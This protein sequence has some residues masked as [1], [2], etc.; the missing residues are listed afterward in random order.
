MYHTAIKRMR[1][2]VC[3]IVF[4]ETAAMANPMAGTSQIQ[5]RAYRMR[6]GNVQM[7]PSELYWR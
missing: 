3:F 5:G 6:N 4:T 7:V 2:N 1:E